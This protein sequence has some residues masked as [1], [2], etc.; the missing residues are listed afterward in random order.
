MNKAELIDVLTKLDT[1][2]RTATDAVE[3]LSTQ[4]CVRCIRVTASPL[5]VSAF[6]NSAVVQPGS[7]VIRAPAR[8]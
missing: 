3:T 2:R 8:Q 6:S 5:P 4:S 7:R 1:D